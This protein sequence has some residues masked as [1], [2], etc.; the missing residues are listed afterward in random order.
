MMTNRE[1]SK[2]ED[3]VKLCEDM[4]VKP[5]KRQASKLRMGKGSLLKAIKDIK[6]K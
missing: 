5:T 1:F 6:R 3:F 4:K 2:T